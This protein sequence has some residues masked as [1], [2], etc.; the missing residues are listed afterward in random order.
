M[1]VELTDDIYAV[2]PTLYSIITHIL[3]VDNQFQG[4]I[5]KK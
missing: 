1:F 5:E 2:L 4:N 3:R